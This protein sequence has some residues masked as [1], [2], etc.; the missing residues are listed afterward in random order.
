VRAR[1]ISVCFMFFVLFFFLL[2]LVFSCQYKCNCSVCSPHSDV[3]RLCNLLGVL[4]VISSLTLD[5][6]SS[7][8]LNTA[9]SL[10]KAFCR[11]QNS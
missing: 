7:E 9:H 6:Q 5:S 1:V 8:T 3:L 10:L 4:A 2:V 11:G